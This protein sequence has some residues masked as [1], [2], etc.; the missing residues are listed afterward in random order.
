ML[1]DFL[2]DNEFFGARQLLVSSASSKTA[3]GTAYCLKQNNTDC[4]LVALTS[5]QNIGFVR[6]LACYDEV[7]P[8][9]EMT[10]AGSNLATTYVD[11][12]GNEDLRT[13]VHTHFGNNL[14]Y[15]CFAGSAQNTEILQDLDQP[16][17]KA[18]V[19]FAPVQIRKRNKDY[20]PAELTRQFSAAQNSFIAHVAAETPPWM[21]IVEHVGVVAAANLVTDLHAGR[22]AADIGNVIRIDTC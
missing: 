21:R 19:F 12:S 13:S 16:G 7:L 15:D 6:G 9:T 14:A 1:A 18:K 8:Y 4:H 3:Y 5:P 10:K 22:C 17:P 2:T 11:F 20:G